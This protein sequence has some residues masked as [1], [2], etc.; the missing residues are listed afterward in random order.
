MSKNKEVTYY[1][2]YRNATVQAHDDKSSIYK[3]EDLGITPS[4]D[5]NQLLITT[6]G[7]LNAGKIAEDLVNKGGKIN[8]V[9]NLMS[10]VKQFALLFNIITN[11]YLKLY[12][13]SKLGLSKITDYKGNDVL[14]LT[15]MIII[16]A[17]LDEVVQSSMAIYEIY[18]AEEKEYDND[19]PLIVLYNA[20]YERLRE[21]AEGFDKWFNNI[22]CYE[23]GDGVDHWEEHKRSIDDPLS[24]FD[25]DL[26]SIS[27]LV[28]DY[29]FVIKEALY[30]FMVNNKK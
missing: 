24:S 13:S 20:V 19:D 23:T 12:A 16:K 6:R 21:L 4:L 2:V 10:F 26:P 22:A 17:C 11:K 9:F 8:P 1:E 7:L 14:P 27:V 30:L 28:R 18:E 25:Y 29:D 5:V 3:F 15:D